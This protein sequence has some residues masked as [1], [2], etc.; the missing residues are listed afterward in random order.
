MSGSQ[1]PERRT[2]GVLR[3]HG[4][5]RRNT[6]PKKRA[7]SIEAVIA[8][9]SR[10]LPDETFGMTNA[11]LSQGTGS[12]P[13]SPIVLDDGPIDVSISQPTVDGKEDPRLGVVPCISGGNVT[14]PIVI[15]GNL[16]PHP[17]GRLGASA[18]SSIVC[19]PSRRSRRIAK[20]GGSPDYARIAYP[21]RRL[22]LT[23][24]SQVHQTEPRKE[25]ED[26]PDRPKSSTLRRRSSAARKNRNPSPA[27]LDQQRITTLW[28]QCLK[29]YLLCME[30]ADD[31]NVYDLIARPH[32]LA[33]EYPLTHITECK[34]LGTSKDTGFFMVH[35]RDTSGIAQVDWN[36]G[37]KLLM[38]RL[39]AVCQDQEDGTTKTVHGAVMIGA[40]VRFYKRQGAEPVALVSFENAQ[41]TLHIETDLPTII[42]HLTAI[43]D[44]W[45]LEREVNAIEAAHE[46]A[47]EAETEY[48]T[49]CVSEAQ[50]ESEIVEEWM[51]WLNEEP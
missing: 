48:T 1:S 24:P 12:T 33:L 47:H 5:R 40:Y 44:E 16:Q 25:P 34:R 43:R 9:S 15:S 30:V 3:P 8:E 18:N 45:E 26:A 17:R 6:N 29:E 7:S 50:T 36:L 37:Q 38:D 21:M 35:F 49:K 2:T 20:Q 14:Q 46:A 11:S 23:A 51:T 32:D 27:K 39:P 19:S 10:L 22:R 31:A 42:K 28:Q 4:Y 41:D 13:E